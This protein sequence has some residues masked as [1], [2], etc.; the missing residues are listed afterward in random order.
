M[1]SKSSSSRI[2]GRVGCDEKG[3]DR[4]WIIDVEGRDWSLKLFVGEGG[5]MCDM[6]D[7]VDVVVGEGDVG[8]RRHSEG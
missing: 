3:L 6:G 4:H 8:W 1:S 2:V 7:G 5:E